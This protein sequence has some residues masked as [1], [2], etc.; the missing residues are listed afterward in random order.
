MNEVEGISIR[1]GSPA[2]APG[3]AALLNGVIAEGRPVLL[4]GHYTDE[5]ERAFLE[6]LPARGG[7]HVAEVSAEGSA[8]P[9]KA[10]GGDGRGGERRAPPAIVAAQVLVPYAAGMPAH[11]HVAEMGTWVRADWRRRGLG[12][13]LWE[14]TLA[15][16]RPRGFTKVFTDI[17][18]DNVESLAYHLALGFTVAGTARG[19]AV[20]GGRAYDVVMVER[21]L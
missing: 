8:H 4:M 15:A 21:F 1:L 2:D 19:Q 13:A 20:M 5:A 18:A 3:M 10:G 9:T 16:A 7:F 11:Q 17:R 14:H 6:G 12:R